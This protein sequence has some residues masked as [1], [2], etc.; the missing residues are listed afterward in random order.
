MPDNQNAQNLKSLMKESSYYIID[1]FMSVLIGLGVTI[2]LNIPMKFLKIINIDLGGFIIHILSMCIALYK[3][4]YSRSYNAN[5]RTYTFH[6][7][8]ALLY[9]GMAFAAQILLTIIIG[10]HAVY[11]SGPT[12]FLSSFVFPGFDRTMAEGRLMI[13]GYDWLFMILADILIYA[14]IMILGEYLGDKQNKKELAETKK[15]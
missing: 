8:K 2:L 13:A 3:R 4:S 7:K 10:S 9:I 14:P 6:F 1:F 12:V 11:I 5:T 15:A